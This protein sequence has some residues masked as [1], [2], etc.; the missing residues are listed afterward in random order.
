MDGNGPPF[1]VGQF[2]VPPGSF[3]WFAA[4]TPPGVKAVAKNTLLQLFPVDLAGLGDKGVI[5]LAVAKK[6]VVFP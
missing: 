1:L 4:I 3:I 6:Q 5:N 2:A